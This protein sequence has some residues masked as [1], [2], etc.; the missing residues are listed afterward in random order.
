[1]TPLELLAPARNADIGIAAIDSGADAVYIA[2]PFF[3]ARKDAGNSVEEI[4]RLCEYA[5]RFGAR[6]FVTVN[7]SVSD[8]ELPE[9]HRQ[10]LLEQAAGVDAFIIRD[11]RICGWDDITVPLHAS[12]QC[13]IR[14]VEDARR[15]EALGCSRLVLEREL[16][17]ETVKAIRKAVS[18][19]LEVFVH[20]A[21]CVCYSG[22]CS[23][24]AY[25][26]GRSADRGECIQA[27]RSLYD[28]T[29]SEGRV[30]V[31]NKALLSLKDLN[32]HARLSELADAGVCSFKIEGRLKNISY[33]RNITRWYSQALDDITA[34]RP[35]DFRRGSYGTVSGGFSTDPWKT[36]NRGYTELF[37]DG[38]RGRW[39]SMDA[40]TNLGTPVGTVSRIRHSRS[41]LELVITPEKGGVVLGNGDGFSFI[42]GNSV[43]GFRGDVCEGLTIT[44]KA[45]EGLREGTRLYRNIDAA[46]ERELDR[47]LPKREIPVSLEAK[48]SGKWSIEIT[49]TSQDG[50]RVVSPFKADV[51]TAENRARA[52]AMFHEQ[53]SKR[54]G[55]YIFSLDRLDAGQLPLLSASILNSMRR[56]VAEDL[57]SMPCGTVPLLNCARS[58]GDSAPDCHSEQTCHSERSEESPAPVREPLMRSKYCI[59][60]ELGMCPVHQGA[61]GSGPLFLLNNGRR[62]ALNFDCKAC[63]MTVT[64]A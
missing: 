46:F 37:I 31:R 36:F 40:P 7:I 63:E 43:V 28:L 62:L 45:V 34:G 25:L 2:G 5:H 64:Q 38:K 3:G 51:E 26:D 41:G 39:S 12:T 35:D 29:D 20:G 47:N 60:Y 55:H 17:L 58:S 52:A 9:L 32:L 50:R 1:M 8:E 33:V 61:A 6:I 22:E 18:C 53:L 44:C 13:A 54:S 27:C 21:L 10:M 42:R 30:L 11:E 23:L 16:P 49:A 15:Y 4:A 14:T 56:L 19:E 24:S 48:V 59:R 57:D